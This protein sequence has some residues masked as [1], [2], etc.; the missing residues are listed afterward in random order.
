MAK[1]TLNPDTKIC[2]YPAY[3]TQKASIFRTSIKS[4]NWNGLPINPS[5]KR[6][7]V[8]CSI[9]EK[10]TENAEEKRRILKGLKVNDELEE[11][12]SLLE[13]EIGEKVVGFVWNPPW[14]NLPQRYKLI[15]TTSL[16]FIICNMDK[17]NFLPFIFETFYF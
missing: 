2:Y 10:E 6:F 17:V 7:K 8:S 3:T 1:F 4:Q 15:G 16:A 14:K 12:V 9:K 5:L 13:A 11:K